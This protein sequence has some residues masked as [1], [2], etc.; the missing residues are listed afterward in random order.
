MWVFP[1]KIYYEE[2]NNG[3]ANSLDFYI[4]FFYKHLL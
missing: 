4:D 1:G 3:G 2:E